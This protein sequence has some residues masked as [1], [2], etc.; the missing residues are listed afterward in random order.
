MEVVL[1][2]GF[3]VGLT[4]RFDA[5]RNAGKSGYHAEFMNSVEFGHDLFGHLLGYLEFA[6]AVSTEG[7]AGWEGTF[8]PGLI[9]KLS[10]NLEFNVGVDIG[11][12]RSADNWDAY[13]GMTWRY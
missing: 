12:T 2:S 5:V 10:E 13:A 8:D 7:N 6:S 4:S 1:P 11:L 3:Y 9:Y